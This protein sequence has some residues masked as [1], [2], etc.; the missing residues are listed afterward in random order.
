[1]LKSTYSSKL[2]NKEDRKRVHESHS[3]GEIKLTSGVEG[4]GREGE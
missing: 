1:M 4:R 2:G 3:K